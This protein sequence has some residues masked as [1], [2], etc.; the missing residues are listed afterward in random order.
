MIILCY[1][2]DLL[3]I[4]VFFFEYV[5]IKIVVRWWIFEIVVV[6]IGVNRG[7]GFEMVK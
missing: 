1:L 4:F 5:E 2:G 7:I 6:V 3:D